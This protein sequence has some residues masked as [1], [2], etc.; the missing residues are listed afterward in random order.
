M[1]DYTKQIAKFWPTIMHAWEAHADKHPVIE[2]DLASEKV[3][4]YNSTEYIGS[5]SERTRET[6]RREFSRTMRE[7]NIMVFVKDSKKRT[8]Q[9]YTLPITSAVRERKP[10]RVCRISSKT[11]AKP[12]GRRRAP[13][14]RLPVGRTRAI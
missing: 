12:A 9:S 8:L 7:G 6:T 14:G 4:A 13:A 1:R 3:Y 5:L 11:A 10:N 2:C